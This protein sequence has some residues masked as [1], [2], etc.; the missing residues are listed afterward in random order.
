M[1]LAVYYDDLSF[2]SLSLCP[3]C[4]LR[5]IKKWHQVFMAGL[6][7]K[8]FPEKSNSHSVAFGGS[9][10]IFSEGSFCLLFNRG[11]GCCNAE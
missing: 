11:M 5:L 7:G 8:K 6:F 1:D 9:A 2:L 4:P 3:L 10:W